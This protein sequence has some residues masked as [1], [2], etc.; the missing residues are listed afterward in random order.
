MTKK[1]TNKTNKSKGTTVNN[2]IVIN[3]QVNQS[4]TQN[5]TQNPTTPENPSGQSVPVAP[6]T[7]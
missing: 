7:Q 1:K 6:E 2:N 5:P 4:Q 3:V